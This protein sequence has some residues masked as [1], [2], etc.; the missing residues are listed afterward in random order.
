MPFLLL[1]RHTQRH[2]FSQILMEDVWVDFTTIPSFDPATF[3]TAAAVRQAIRYAEKMNIH[4]AVGLTEKAADYFA[5]YKFVLD[6]A[7]YILMEPSIHWKHLRQDQEHFWE[8]SVED[9][10]LYRLVISFG[11]SAYLIMPDG[12][13]Q[14]LSDFEVLSYEVSRLCI[15]TATYLYKK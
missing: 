15:G 7:R 10:F 12:T 6:Q 2:Y 5:E 3:P 11:D 1:S 8:L 4:S 14:C 9:A 13:L